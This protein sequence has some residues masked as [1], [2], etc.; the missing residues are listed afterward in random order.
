MPSN[1][2]YNTNTS[3]LGE[4]KKNQYST[5]RYNTLDN[6]VA[7]DLD[8]YRNWGVFRAPY[9]KFK[10]QYDEK[11]GA[12]IPGTGEGY[13]HPATKS[14]FNN[15]NAVTF[16]APY[17]EAI[18][19][20]LWDEPTIRARM[21]KRGLC[22]IK[23]LIRASED[24]EMGR[25]I[26]SYADFM[27]CK[28]LGRTS[29]NYLVTL[30]RFPFPCG[31]HI[32]LY[33]TSG[34]LNEDEYELQNH[35]PDIGRLVTWMGTPGNDM[36]NILSYDY[37]MPFKE[38]T[39]NIQDVDN[40]GEQ[41]GM[42][43]ALMNAANPRY[44]N[45]TLS[46]AYGDTSMRYINSALG[47]GRIANF[48]TG[49][50]NSQLDFSSFIDAN[51]TYGPQDVISK[52][53]IRTGAGEGGGLEFNQNITLTFDYELR[54]Y[55]GI[56]TK[57][58][59]LDLIG[60]ILAVT[61]TKGK[62][63]GGGFR[64]VGASQSNVFANMPIYKLKH[65]DLWNNDGSFNY[66]SLVDA[67]TSSLDMGVTAL[68]GGKADFSS[69]KGI[70]N[71]LAQA[72]LGLGKGMMDTLLGGA[73]NSLGRP[74]KVALNSLLSPAPTGL[75]HLT[76]GNP[77]HPILSMGNMIID[78]CKITQ[79]GPLGLDDFPT[80][81]KVE[82]TLKHGKPRDAQ[83]IEQM[84]TMGDFRLY[85]NMNGA[86]KEMYEEAVDYRNSEAGSVKKT[87]E[88]DTGDIFNGWGDNM[89]PPDNSDDVVS[90]GTSA[91]DPSK[92]VTNT[93]NGSDKTFTVP[94][95]VYM[96]YFGTNDAHNINWAVKEAGEGST[97]NNWEKPKAEPAS[98]SK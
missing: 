66:K 95:T 37:K 42:M 75:W 68:T 81:L 89:T 4:T 11:S 6:G 48:F 19:A 50:A 22:T 33:N 67:T 72:A 18:N 14:L 29:N 73:L 31:D 23:E 32:S 35:M 49:S 56:N 39:A 27:Y 83:A 91:T 97:R 17:Q 78:D 61:Y 69:F 2:I 1:T 85:N 3:S 84:Y 40:R 45:Q 20:P 41:G 93:T 96:K 98:G 36:E 90:K 59:F 82:V 15:S 44:L 76:I 9:Q 7:K 94:K 16:N 55:D 57:A 8:S 25:A 74:Q 51:K 10:V 5:D 30:R 88:G 21:H 60:N 71:T 46:G 53:F 13:N 12:P 26:Y 43:G 92:G 86:I 65:D 62:F 54:S 63:W 79:Y 58:A 70:M 34:S 87:H 24:G 77:K 47:G 38:L 80:G 64:S 52:T 28:Y